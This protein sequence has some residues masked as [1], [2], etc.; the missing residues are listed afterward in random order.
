MKYLAS[1]IVAL[2]VVAAPVSAAKIIIK[3]IAT[4]NLPGYRTF[5]LSMLTEGSE[6]LRG[7]DATFTGAL[8]QV[9]PAG[10]PT[11]LNDANG[12]F[13]FVGADPRQD[14]QFPFLSSTVLTIGGQESNT[15]LKA[16]ISG[17]ADNGLSNPAPFA[18]LVTP[19]PFSIQTSLSFDLGGANP[20]THSGSLFQEILTPIFDA[21]VS[22][23]SAPAEGLDGHRTYTLWLDYL[24]NLGSV[25]FDAAITGDLFQ[26]PGSPSPFQSDAPLGLVET[27]SHFL[28]DRGDVAI[29]D[30]AAE[31]D[32]I[33]LLQSDFFLDLGPP[34]G[35]TSGRVAI[36]QVTTDDPSNV[37]YDFSLEYSFRFPPLRLTGSLI[38]E[39]ATS[40][41]LVIAALA[42]PNRVRNFPAFRK[43]NQ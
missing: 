21:D 11:I 15:L 22:I 8:N 6:V 16:A 32:T 3:Q 34:A 31:A 13:Q 38:P 7:V 1:V 35:P 9:N 4:P 41:L 24:T 17:L 39:P 23:E 42:A 14:S 5:T 40:L 29:F 43:E 30:S 27:D 33:A 12:F 37:A 19:D 20:V 25:K 36:A 2:F 10:Q 26:A 18:Q 28:F